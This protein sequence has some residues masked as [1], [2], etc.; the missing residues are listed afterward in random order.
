MPT[1]A[2]DHAQS[3]DRGVGGMSEGADEGEGIVGHPAGGVV[4]QS[5]AQSEPRIGHGAEDELGVGGGAQS[6][7]RRSLKLS[8][9]FAQLARRQEA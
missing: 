3:E 2:G 5:P 1:G 9:D 6:L 7:Q 4:E 8:P